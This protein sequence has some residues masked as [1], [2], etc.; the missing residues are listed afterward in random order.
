MCTADVYR[1]RRIPENKTGK[2]RQSIEE[3]GTSE[4]S[5][6]VEA[7]SASAHFNEAVESLKKYRS[8]L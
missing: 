6:D 2:A 5:S 4:E 8:M 1:V 3:K 7:I